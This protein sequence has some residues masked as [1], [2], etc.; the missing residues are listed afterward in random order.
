MHPVGD[1]PDAWAGDYR[2]MLGDALLVAPILAA[3]GVRDVGLP[4]GRWYD[5]WDPAAAPIDGP[6]TV[7][8]NMPERERIPLFVKEGAI[9]PMEPVTGT[10]TVRVWP[11]AVETAFTSEIDAGTE[12]V[13]NAQGSVVVLQSSAALPVVLRVHAA[14]APSGVTRD[15]TAVPFTFDDAAREVVVE[16][17][18]DGA[19]TIAIQP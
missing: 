19:A 15:G 14:A 5:W 11:A 18:V 9:L 8:V 6:T 17:A 2:W 13:V 3:G 7:A 12:L 10:M 4:A 1:G 16:L